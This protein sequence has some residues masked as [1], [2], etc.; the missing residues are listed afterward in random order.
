VPQARSTVSV[1]NPD[2]DRKSFPECAALEGAQ[3]E[4]AFVSSTFPNCR[5]MTGNLATSGLVLDELD[6]VDMFVFI[7]HS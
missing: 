7:G 5:I 6:R 4:T 2:F 3:A 1:V